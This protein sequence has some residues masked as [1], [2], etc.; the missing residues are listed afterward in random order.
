[1]FDS[2]TIH[3]P[4]TILYARVMVFITKFDFWRKHAYAA[5]VI[6][7]WH[8]TVL[9]YCIQRSARRYE[10]DRSGKIN[11]RNEQRCFTCH[12]RFAVETRPC[13]IQPCCGRNLVMNTYA[14]VKWYLLIC[15]YVTS[16]GLWNAGLSSLQLNVTTGKSYEPQL[17]L[18]L[19]LPRYNCDT[20]IRET[21]E[22]HKFHSS[23]TWA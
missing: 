8:G 22:T 3:L 21:L 7:P 14:H 13:A 17:N 2:W 4:F 12:R 23:S 15:R 11:R 9:K 19:L 16:G 5:A 18:R 1:M 20:K 6:Q 10:S